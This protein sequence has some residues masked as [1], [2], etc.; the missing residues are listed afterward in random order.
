M[1]PEGGGAVIF[2]RVLLESGA[3][4]GVEPTTVLDRLGLARNALDD[5][6]AW[7]AAETMT[8]AWEL[9]PELSNDPD[10]GL[11]AAE[12]TPSGVYGVLEYATI[13]SPTVAI[14][15]ARIERYYRL[16][17]AMSKIRFERDGTHAGISLEPV[18]GGE[19]NLRHYAE[20][21]FA[22]L[23]T[24]LS[25]LTLGKAA[26]LAVD[27]AH[28]APSSTTEHERVFGPNVRFSRPHAEL[29][30]EGAALDA[31]LTTSN[32]ALAGVLAQTEQMLSMPA[33]VT[34]AERVRRELPAALSA[35]DHRLS[36][37]AKRLGLAAR[38]L[39]QKLDEE[40]ESFNGL[41]DDVRKELALAR[42]RENEMSLGEIAFVLGFTQTSTFHRAFKRWTGTTPR[43]YR[44]ARPKDR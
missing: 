36:S 1:R 27:F 21:F 8:R 29:L 22:L 7:I 11:H 6:N 20:H 19:R 28:P 15:L 4:F 14:A 31:P 9:V 32:A 18:V 10:F 34:V 2:L 3:R 24:R 42:V 5:Q 40:N 38:T 17:G 12:T 41:V 26:P 25:S 30:F 44:T 39:E 37:I 43:E 13:T 33:A 23:A 16:I 35:G